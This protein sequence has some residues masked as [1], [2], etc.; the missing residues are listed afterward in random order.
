MTFSLEE[1]HVVPFSGLQSCEA[2]WSEK[3]TQ[4]QAINGILLM[5]CMFLSNWDIIQYR[6]YLWK[7]TE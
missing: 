5:F 6:G 3:C 7:I 1:L 4:L 2:H